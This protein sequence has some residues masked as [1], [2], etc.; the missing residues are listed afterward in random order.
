MLAAPSRNPSMTRPSTRLAPRLALLVLAAPLLTGCMIF[1]SRADKQMEK[2]PNFKDGYSDGCAT[3]SGG[4]ADM[5]DQA[6]VRDKALFRSDKA[7]R[8]GWSAGYTACRQANG[9]NVPT[10]SGPIADPYP[11]R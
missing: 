7:Y 4:S 10:Q 2:S 6:D 8:M 9:S 5:R 1:E 11:P 3:A